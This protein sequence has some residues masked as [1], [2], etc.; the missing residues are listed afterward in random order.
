M[1]DDEEFCLSRPDQRGEP[2]S[3][4]VSDLFSGVC[5]SLDTIQKLCFN[6]HAN[7]GESLL[8][9]CVVGLFPY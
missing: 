4:S 1:T 6:H 3:L 9:V 8:F 5:P 2:A 7:D